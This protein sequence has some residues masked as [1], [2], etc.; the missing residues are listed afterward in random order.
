MITNLST[1]YL[2]ADFFRLG[3]DIANI[4]SDSEDIGFAGS[5][6]WPLWVNGLEFIK[7]RPLFGYGLDN[8]GVRYALVKHYDRSTTQ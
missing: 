7:Q 2:L 5:A 4:L 6:R 1:N 8:L 3:N